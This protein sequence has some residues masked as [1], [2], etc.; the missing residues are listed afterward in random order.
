MWSKVFWQ[1]SAERAIKTFT[2]VVATFLVA[3]TTGFMDVDWVQIVSLAGVA[4]LLSVL[5]SVASDGV[6]TEGTASLIK[7]E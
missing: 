6:G 7:G 1:D 5:T 2:Q 4:A 3:G